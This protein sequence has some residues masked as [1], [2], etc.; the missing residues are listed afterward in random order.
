LIDLA[1][2]GGP[3]LGEVGAFAAFG[4]ML[5][6]MLTLVYIAGLAER[7]DRAFVGLGLDS[8]AVV[9]IYAVGIGIL[10]TLR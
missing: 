10:Y 4:A 3:V 6:A 2:P 1:Y 5:G 8:W 7:R 9:A